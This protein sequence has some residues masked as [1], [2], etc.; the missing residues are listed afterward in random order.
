VIYII[1]T[2]V[3]SAA[4]HAWWS[5]RD[6]SKRIKQLGADI[7]AGHAREKL[8]EAYDDT[9]TTLTRHRQQ[10]HK[11]MTRYPVEFCHD[12]GF[13]FVWAGSEGQSEYDRL[14][15]RIEPRP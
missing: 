9:W 5:T 14:L 1:V 13:C 7:A 15:R 10:L 2:I 8:H 11:S 12:A 6:I 4:I 3:L